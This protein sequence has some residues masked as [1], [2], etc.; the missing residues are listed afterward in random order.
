MSSR[1]ILAV[2]ASVALAIPCS[3]DTV[4]DFETPALG[5]SPSLT[6]D[7]YVA[8]TVTFTAIQRCNPGAV[9]GV[10][11]ESRFTGCSASPPTNQLLG[12]GAFYDVSNLAKNVIQAEF[13][14]E[15][16]VTAV[17]VEVI[18]SGDAQVFLAL[19]DATGALIASDSDFTL[20]PQRPCEL[21]Q[22][23]AT[24]SADA[25]G[26]RVAYARIDSDKASFGSTC[27][28]FCGRCWMFAIDNF[29]FQHEPVNDVGLVT[30]TP[31]VVWPPSHGLVTVQAGARPQ[32]ECQEP[33]LVTLVSITSDEPD[34]GT[35]DED[36]PNDVQGADLG[37][38][39]FEFALRA[40][41]S[42]E[43]D[44]RTYAVCYEVRCAGGDIRQECAPVEVPHDRG[45]ARM[46]A[47]GVAP[48]SSARAALP[49]LPLPARGRFGDAR[50]PLE[51]RTLCS[52][53]W[54]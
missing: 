40:E 46:T 35:G 2:L 6:I 14:P 26:R 15:M 38:A 7:P 31:F 13:A 23:R 45:T 11:K 41:R 32:G 22:A 18:T 51:R 20:P 50:L 9:V 34:A 4:I 1:R 54:S 16:A 30:L 3:A 48:S 47:R 17:S 43:S 42:E 28:D 33:Q 19:Y 8:N 49:T 12:T 52:A 37:T 29:T 36:L 53:A 39:D 25:V 5:S 27:G 44:G 21:Y 10:I 24:L